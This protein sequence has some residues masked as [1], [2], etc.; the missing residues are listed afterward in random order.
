MLMQ[1]QL[2]SIRLKPAGSS[3]GNNYRL[4]QE[5][6]DYALIDDTTINHNAFADLDE[7]YN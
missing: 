5:T 2:G 4:L 1:E 3:L 6:N 7:T